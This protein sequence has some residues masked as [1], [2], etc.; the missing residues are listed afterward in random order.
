MSRRP[1][2]QDS[3]RLFSPRRMVSRRSLKLWTAEEEHSPCRKKRQDRNLPTYQSLRFIPKA[4]TVL[5]QEESAPTIPR[6]QI[7][8]HVSASIS[9]LERRNAMSSPV[10]S[11]SIRCPSRA[12]P[13]QSNRK[14]TLAQTGSKKST[15]TP[16][17]SSTVRTS[18]ETNPSQQSPIR[19]S[20]QSP[21]R[22]GVTRCTSDRASFGSPTRQMQIESARYAT[23]P[24]KKFSSL[25][26]IVAEYDDLMLNSLDDD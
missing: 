3:F 26:D 24:R 16:A 5:V 13:L 2:A 1:I 17:E 8:R 11:T 6:R 9:G 4:A 15:T 14:C 10:R 25:K 20:P 12:T 23:S 19:M 22:R 7:T 18:I 21:V